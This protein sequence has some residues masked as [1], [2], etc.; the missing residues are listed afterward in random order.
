MRLDPARFE[1]L[2]EAFP[3][4]SEA[5]SLVRHMFQVP[6]L[7]QRGRMLCNDSEARQRFVQEIAA[8]YQALNDQ[9]Y[10]LRHLLD[11]VLLR[12][13]IPHFQA[14]TGYAVILSQC[15]IYHCILTGPKFGQSHFHAEG[16][17]LA[18]ATLCL[19][20]EVEDLSPLGSAYMFLALPLV[21][22]CVEDVA[23]KALI[24]SAIRD[25]LRN[26]HRGMRIELLIARIEELRRDLQFET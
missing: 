17:A 14:L 13:S 18:D 2:V 20:Q 10:E 25:L 9:R 5:E 19:A 23:T 15:S 12:G 1:E 21:G 11:T 4:D 7:L 22:L 8:A 6:R 24:G 16:G 26:Y 3:D